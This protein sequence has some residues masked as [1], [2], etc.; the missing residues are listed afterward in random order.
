MT[1]LP[2]SHFIISL[3]P[4]HR[5]LLSFTF[6]TPFPST[7]FVHF[8]FRFATQCPLDYDCFFFPHITNWTRISSFVPFSLSLSHCFFFL[9]SSSSILLPFF[10]HSFTFLLSLLT[11]FLFPLLFSYSPFSSLL[12]YCFSLLL[13]FSISFPFFLP[14]CSISFLFHYLF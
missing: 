3:S 6:F 8:F 9:F 7:Q 1:T 10:L 2:G 11:C 14:S 4:A 13:S 5:Q 12:S